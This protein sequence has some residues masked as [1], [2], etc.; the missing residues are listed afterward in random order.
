MEPTQTY[1]YVA[2]AGRNKDD[3]SGARRQAPWRALVVGTDGLGQGNGWDHHTDES[4][5]CPVI[6][7]VILCNSDYLPYSDDR[8]FKF[9]TGTLESKVSTCPLERA[10][11]ST[12]ARS[13]G[14][15]G[16]ISCSRAR[17]SA[18]WLALA[19]TSLYELLESSACA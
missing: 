18:P 11:P 17:R 14:R 1:A 6:V 13:R 19:R 4:L 9:C 8:I 12:S 2:W 5:D 10:V 15:N 16:G 3:H 7:F